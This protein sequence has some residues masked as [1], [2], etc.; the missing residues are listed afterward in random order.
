MRWLEYAAFLVAVIG[1][2]RPVGLY[3][4]RVFEG[5]PLPLIRC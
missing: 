5:S 3:V 2:A 1:L 4:A